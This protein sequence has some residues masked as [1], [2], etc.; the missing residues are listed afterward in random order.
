MTS[1]CSKCGS[2]D[3]RIRRENSGAYGMNT[4]PLG[5]GAKS[6]S[7]FDN[8][9]CLDC[10]YVEFFISNPDALRKIADTWDRP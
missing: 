1:P 6:T 9:V 3:L 5:K 10:G 8:L 4:V 2:S 7:A